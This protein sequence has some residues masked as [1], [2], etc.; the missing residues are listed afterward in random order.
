[1]RNPSRE[2]QG[3][4]PETGRN[5]ERK[6]QLGEEKIRKLLL[7]LRELPQGN[8]VDDQNSKDRIR[9]AQKIF[10]VARESGAGSGEMD[11]K[12]LDAVTDD[13]EALSAYHDL[14]IHGVNCP[15][16]TQEEILSEMEI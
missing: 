12:H 4:G 5:P 10:F 2:G 3:S 9:L 8:D 1:M 7:Q 15:P 11:D 14:W 16:E 13:V 6:R